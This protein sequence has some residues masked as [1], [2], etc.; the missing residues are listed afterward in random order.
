M[1][2]VLK[3]FHWCQRGPY[4]FHVSHARAKTATEAGFCWPFP[5]SR[6]ETAGARVQSQTQSFVQVGSLRE[7]FSQQLFCWMKEHLSNV[8][9]SD[10]IPSYCLVHRDPCNGFLQSLFNLV[11][12]V[13]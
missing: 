4:R 1:E 5:W 10:E 7:E 9:N 13:V 3:R 2:G 11:V 6:F 8:Q 12:T